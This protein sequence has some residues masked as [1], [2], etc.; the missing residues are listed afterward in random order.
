MADRGAGNGWAGVVINGAVR[1]VEALSGIALGVKALGS[2]PRRSGKD[3]IG[4][5]DV[6]V[7][8]GGV[9]FRPGQHHYSDADGILVTRT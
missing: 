7:T 9:K 2:N 6:E 8:F 1:Y 5:R 4:Q 3:D